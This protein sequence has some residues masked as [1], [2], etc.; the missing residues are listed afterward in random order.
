MTC[1][2]RYDVFNTFEKR[3]GIIIILIFIGDMG[4]AYEEYV[5]G[6]GTQVLVCPRHTP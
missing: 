2:Q 3:L 5:H 6:V 4:V 1:C